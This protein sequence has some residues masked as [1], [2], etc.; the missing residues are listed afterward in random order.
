MLGL[1]YFINL[2]KKNL[3]FYFRIFL[4]YKINNIINFTSY[5]LIKLLNFDFHIFL[6]YYLVY[7]KYVL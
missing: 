7:I 2:R 4:F 6:L 5:T 3:D 1:W